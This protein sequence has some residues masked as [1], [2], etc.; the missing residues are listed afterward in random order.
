[1]LLGLLYVVLWSSASVAAKFLRGDAA[2]LTAL[3]LRFALAGGLLSIVNY[4]ILKQNRLPKGVEWRHLAVLGFCNSAGY[5]GLAWTAIPNIS[6]GL[7]NLVVASGPFVVA[8]LSKVWLGRAIAGR[9]WL[10]MCIAAAGLLIVIGPSLGDAS[11]TP[12]AVGMVCLA[13]II[14]SI[15]SV[16]AR[17]VQLQL[18]P[19]V[20]NGWQLLI[21]VVMLAPVAALLNNGIALRP[22]LNLVVAVGW[23]GLPVSIGAMAIWFTMVRKDALRASTW[24]F[25]TPVAGYGLAALFL[26]ESVHLWDIMGAVFVM[27]GL[28]VS[29]TIDVRA[30]RALLKQR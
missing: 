11:A 22:S 25:L 13:V 16:Y 4:G 9:E 30:V 6:V 10:G 20:I 19:F 5:L 2:P 12:L 18:S 14:N 3:V 7:F 21:A 8:L 26:G 28:A 17:R 29:G 24:L 1:M 15:G 27:I 23:S